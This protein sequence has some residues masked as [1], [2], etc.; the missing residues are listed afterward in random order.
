MKISSLK[1]VKSSPSVDMCPISEMPEFAFTG[2]SNVGK[3]SLINMLVNRNGFAKTSAKPGK[4]RLINHF[5][6]NNNWY[7]VDLPGYGY[8]GVSKSMRKDWAVFIREYLLTRQNLCCLFVLVDVRIN[9]QKQD[10]DFINNLG[11]NEIPFVIVFTKSD[12]LSKSIL[13]ANITRFFYELKPYWEDL[14][15]HLI[16]SSVIKTGREEILEFIDSS[17]REYRSQRAG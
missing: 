10:L 1:F 5:L 6:I 17:I 12:K 14:P 9:P 8:A 13:N 16:T 11:K 4:T 7:I 2:R 15:N 3:S